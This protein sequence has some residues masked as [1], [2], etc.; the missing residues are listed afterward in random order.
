MKI[1]VINHLDSPG[2]AGMICRRIN[3][4]ILVYGGS[5]FPNNDPLKSSI[6]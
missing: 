2:L 3:N 4:R 6:K 5:Y 1:D